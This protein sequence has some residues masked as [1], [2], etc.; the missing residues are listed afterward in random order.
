[1]DNA[2]QTIVERQVRRVRRRLLARSALHCLLLAWAAALVLTAVWFV[3]RPLAFTGLGE[4]WGW[5]V[6]GA[7]LG[8]ATVAAAVIG[9]L[10]TPN[11]VASALALD[12]QFALKERVTT[13]LTLTPELAASP[14]GQALLH[15]V[16]TRVEKLPVAEKFPLAPP[17][18]AGLMPVGAMALAVLAFFFPALG[19]WHFNASAATPHAEKKVNTQEVQQQLDNLRKAAAETRKPDAEKSKEMKELLD[20]WEK[21]VNKPVDPSNPEQVRERVA[22][23]RSLEQ[24]MKDRAHDLK[25]Q[26]Q[27]HD[28]LKK[29]LEKLNEDGKRLREGPAKDFEDALMKGDFHKAK[30]ALDK[31]AKQLQDHRL[32]KEQQRELAE[33]FKQIQEK[34]QRLQEKDEK[35]KQLKKDFAEGKI[36]KEQLDREMEKFKELQELANLAGE[37][38]D[39]LGGEPDAA[40]AALAKMAKQFEAME[41]SEEELNEIL[42]NMEALNEAAEGVAG[43][44]GEGDENGLGGGGP[45]GG[46]RPID[47]NDPNSKIVQQRQKAQVNPRSQ[48]RVV[49]FTSGG[50]FTKI[51][52]KQVDGAFRQ[53]VQEAPEAIERQNIPEDVADIARGYF[54]KLGGQ[55]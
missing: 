16:G 43:A 34:L 19:G 9:W 54:K 41:L 29:L 12:E 24:K 38:K 6:P 45:P 32:S 1:M 17:W 26:A 39:C 25:A 4:T 22:E 8:A 15:D 35:L 49:G 10:R 20:E 48:Q 42:R 2:L 3:V 40:A 52:A 31:I 33:Q 30:E 51:P 50:N 36:N 44:L 23:M 47:P 14:A 27:K 5:A 46:I 18:R 37:C 28:T 21:L 11:M 13:A 7:L 55:K 53:A